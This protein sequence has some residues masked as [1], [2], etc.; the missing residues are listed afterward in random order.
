MTDEEKVYRTK[1]GR[2]LT[3]D[4]IW[5][6]SEEEATTEYDIS[7]MKIRTDRRKKGKGENGET[8]DEA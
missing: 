7:K 8:S 5:K 3:D 4:D 2:I 1:D 6:L